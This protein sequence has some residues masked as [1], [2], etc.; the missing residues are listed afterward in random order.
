ME[1]FQYNISVMS[2]DKVIRRRLLDKL[3]KVEH[4][5]LS[6]SGLLEEVDLIT[7][8]LQASNGLSL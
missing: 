3:E 1:Q 4:H 8:V 7:G 6:S 2:R 5:D